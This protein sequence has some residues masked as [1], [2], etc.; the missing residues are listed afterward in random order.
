[1]RYRAT[2]GQGGD[3]EAVLIGLDWGSSSCR[4]YLYAADS[5]VIDTREAACGVSTLQASPSEPG[6]YE[7]AFAQMC[8]SWM[9]GRP[10]LPVLACG[11][12]GSDRGWVHVAYRQLPASI[13]DPGPVARVRTKDGIDIH[14]LAGL[15]DA[16]GPGGVMRGEETQLAGVPV[17][18]GEAVVLPGTHSKWVRLS[19]RTVAGFTT[20]MTGEL[21][22]LVTGYSIL[23]GSIEP[24]EEVAWPAFE[25]GVRYA[26][27]QPCPLVSLF[28]ARTRWLAAD[29]GGDEVADYISGLLI[30]TELVDARTGGGADPAAGLVIVGGHT[31]TNRYKRAAGIL[32]WSG[33]RT[34]T[35]ASARGLWNTAS[36]LGLVSAPE[37]TAGAR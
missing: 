19:G 36:R 1:M 33:I 34:V 32:G 14:V 23:A 17:V 21:Y 22:A 28:S 2:A 16:G 26:V 18:N 24:A 29:L 12:V 30:G 35:G 37:S 27:E 8:G 7:Q 5:G 9:A 3:R 15:K 20:Y 6:P 11:M 10:G 25:R 13:D 4:A 31:L